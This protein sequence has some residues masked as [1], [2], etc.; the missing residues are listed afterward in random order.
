MD[1]PSVFWRM[2]RKLYW[3]TTSRPPVTTT[4][5]GGS[6]AQAGEAVSTVARTIADN[7][8]H[9][10]RMK[11]MYLASLGWMRI[12]GALRRGGRRRGIANESLCVPYPYSSLLMGRKTPCGSEAAV[13]LLDDDEPPLEC[14][15]ASS[16]CWVM[17]RP[18][19]SSSSVARSGVIRPTTFRMTKL[20]PP[21]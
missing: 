7:P 2:P 6:C 20:M 21:L 1:T 13:I 12:D 8:K 19:L 16:L 15:Y 5:G 11:D 17:S 10:A 9:T 18:T 14:R 4:T 3:F